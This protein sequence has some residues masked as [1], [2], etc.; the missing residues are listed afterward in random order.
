MQLAGLSFST[1]IIL[2]KFSDRTF[3]VLTNF[4]RFGSII[5]CS[6]SI[7]EID[8]SLDFSTH[9]LLGKREDTVNHI[10]ARQILERIIIVEKELNPMLPI[11]I[12]PVLLAITLKEEL[13]SAVHFKEILDIIIEMYKEI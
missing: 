10:Y 12:K 2:Q 8:Q 3:V 6:A 9:V 4:N 5:E 13:R 7:S 1:T 11:V